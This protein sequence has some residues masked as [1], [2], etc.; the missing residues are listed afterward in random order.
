MTGAASGAR[1]AIIT[2]EGST[3]ST[4]DPGARKTRCRLPRSGRCEPHRGLPYAA[5]EHRVRAPCPLVADPDAV[6]CGCGTH[7]KSPRPPVNPGIRRKPISRGRRGFV[8]PDPTRGTNPPVSVG[9][10]GCL[11]RDGDRSTARQMMRNACK[12][13]LFVT[14]RTAGRSEGATAENR[15]VGGSSPPLAIRKPCKSVTI[16]PVIIPSGLQRPTCSTAL[17]R[18]AA[19]SC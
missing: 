17:A 7:S 4:T 10:F 3:A 18:G 2:A 19:S 13:G 5:R 12:L 14:F 11:G 9:N 6:I 1:W 15:G 8:P 16:S